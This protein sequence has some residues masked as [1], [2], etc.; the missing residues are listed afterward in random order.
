MK[1][2]RSE[3]ELE[4]HERHVDKVEGELGKNAQRFDNR[5]EQA[6]PRTRTKSRRISRY[7]QRIESKAKRLTSNYSICLCL[8]F[9]KCSFISKK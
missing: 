1:S 5:F 7:H 4:E 6:H 2:E 3:R 9:S 8:L